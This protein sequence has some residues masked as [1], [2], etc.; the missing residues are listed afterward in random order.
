[1]S[2][3]GYLSLLLAFVAAIY[4]AIAFAFG[5]RWRRRALLKG[6]RIGL[7]ATCGLVSL[8][9]IILL[10]ALIS[11]QFQLEYVASYT[12]RDLGL[13][14]LIS[15]LWAGNSGSLLFWAWLLSI[16]AAF[17]LLQKRSE[18]RRLVPYTSMVMMLTQAFFLL[19]LLLVAN[20]FQKLTTIPA[21]GMGLNPMLENPGMIIHPPVLLAGYVAFT[22]PFAFAIATLMKDGLVTS[23]SRP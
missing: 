18:G 3:I 2:E 1:M 10:Y 7:F 5:E 12:S 16:F 17:V 9:V 11:H 13:P 20:P 22:V 21:D 6:A 8:S 14:Y 4:T 19:L 15:A 23:G